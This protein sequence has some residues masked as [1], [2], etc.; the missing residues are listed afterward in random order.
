MLPGYTVFS[1]N[2]ARAAA[3]HM[4]AL[5]TVRL[6][7]PLSCGGGGQ[8]LAADAVEM[9]AFLEKFSDDELEKHDS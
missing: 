6:K 2:D 3:K 8:R 9:D 4:L 1:A 5:G 7:R